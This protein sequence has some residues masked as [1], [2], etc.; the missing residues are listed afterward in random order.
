MSTITYY[1]NQETLVQQPHPI[2]MW[3]TKVHVMCTKIR[4]KMLV[5]RNSWWDP[6][7]QLYW[8]REPNLKTQH[9]LRTVIE[10]HEL[11]TDHT[12][13]KQ[14]CLCLTCLV[15]WGSSWVCARLAPWCDL[16]APQLTPWQESPAHNLEGQRT[17]HAQLEEDLEH[18]LLWQWQV[19]IWSL[20]AQRNQAGRSAQRT[21]CQAWAR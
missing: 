12:R 11:R 16:P 10:K 9:W 7:K 6:A 19:D 17:T 14:R 5:N 21:W 3:C 1:F 18:S 13:P 20:Q 8:T 4:Q 15:Q 2:H